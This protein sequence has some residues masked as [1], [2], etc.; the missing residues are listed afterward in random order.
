VQNGRK[1]MGIIPESY[2]WRVKFK[3]IWQILIGAKAEC[4]CGEPSDHVTV[5]EIKNY[6]KKCQVADMAR[7]LQKACASE[8]LF[9]ED[10][11]A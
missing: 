7:R 6:C 1:N 2:T 3:M 8:N 9:D 5:I 10:D 11:D 4:K